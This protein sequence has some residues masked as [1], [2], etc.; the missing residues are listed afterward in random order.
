M[1]PPTPDT[2]DRI[3]KGREFPAGWWRY[4]VL[5]NGEVVLR[6]VEATAGASQRVRYWQPPHPKGHAP[7]PLPPGSE[8]GASGG[9]LVW[10]QPGLVEIRIRAAFRTPVKPLTLPEIPLLPGGASGGG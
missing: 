3:D 5:L 9:H 7:P 6:A 4:E 2:L 10:S 8:D 1:I